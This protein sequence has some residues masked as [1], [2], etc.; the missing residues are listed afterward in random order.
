M[1][2]RSTAFRVT[3]VFSDRER[4]LLLAAR[5]VSVRDALALGDGGHRVQ[6]HRT[7]SPE[8]RCRNIAGADRAVGGDVKDLIEDVQP[9]DDLERRGRVA[10]VL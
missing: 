5:H 7:R 8:K 10:G 2:V 9:L 6:A 4:A 1:A 3:R